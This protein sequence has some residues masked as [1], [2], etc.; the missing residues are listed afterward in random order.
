MVF[1]VR[2][3][4]LSIKKEFPRKVREVEHV[5][6][7]MSDGTRLA[8]RIW[9]PEDAEQHPVPVILEYI[10]YRKNDFTA[11]RDSIRHP[12]FAGHGYASIRVDMRGSGDS[13]GI[14]YDE[15]L[16]QEQEDA[17]DVLS[18]IESQPWSTGAVG[19]IG[20]SWG[21][22][23]GL[24]VAAR[25]HPALKAIITLCSTDDRYADDVHY[26][27]GCLLASDMLWW[28]STMLVYSG[29]PA[30]PR[31]VGDEW[32]STWLER[33]EKTP[34]YVEEWVK[35]QRRDAFWKHGSVCENYT[36]INIPVFAVGGWTDGYT[37]S[38]LRLL[39]GLSG[40]RKGLIGPWAH[41]YPEVAV[42]GPA[43]GFL[44]ECLRWWDH[45]LKGVDTGIMEEPMLRA[46]MQESVLPQ[47]DYAERPGRW[48]AETEWPS[49]NVE[50]VDFWLDGGLLADAPAAGQRISIPS[51]QTHGLYAG[52]WCP[53]GQA[54][55]LASD[56][57]LENGL[58]VCF[59]SEPLA[60]P[61][62]ILGFPEVT[63]ELASDRQRALLAVRL[64]D[65][66]PDGASTLVSWGMLNLT[67]RDSHEHPTPLVPGKRY[68]VTVRL[69]AVGHVL[70]AGHRWQVALSPTYWPHAWPS[71]EPVTLQVFAGENTRL[72]LPVRPHRALDNK[73]PYFDVPETAAVL[74]REILRT[75]SRTRKVHHDLIEG[76]WILEDFS[77]EGARRLPSNGIEYGSVNRN[78]YS[79]KDGDPL[80]AAVRCEWSLH[81]GRGEWQTRLES[82]STMT[83]DAEQF[84]ITNELIAFEGEE[85]VF[86]KTWK[87]EIPRDL[88]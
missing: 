55:D 27:G 3:N 46:W 8:A 7:P 11:L 67:H 41:E 18:W 39:E 79:I 59:T 19:M 37:N 20:K 85:Q 26:M 29:R 69:N 45:W 31:I 64:C 1:N 58:S 15:Y 62:E 87:S 88:V 81:V 44:Q 73:L 71:P 21:G 63:V 66:S 23:N 47:V 17:L 49:P 32:R 35:H 30:D 22:F 82:V 51:V 38:I 33:L 16:P 4:N 76:T 65:V 84:F 14:L 80:S 70:P 52:V 77:D 68:T 53:F 43:I 72:T 48:V 25:R 13:D 40:P 75:E 60:A 83:A 12:Y 56:Q 61:Q 6:I 78:V 34:P 10:P 9:I 5:W 86:S 57:R 50:A 36:D 54:G 2:D 24:Q 28:A 42:P 74:E